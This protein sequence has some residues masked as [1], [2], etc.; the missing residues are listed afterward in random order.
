M[1]S[2]D[3]LYQDPGSAAPPQVRVSFAP[4]SLEVRGADGLLVTSW[5]YGDLRAV[6]AARPGQSIVL[7][8]TRTPA[9][10]LTIYD[11]SAVLPFLRSYAP[12]A[13]TKGRHIRFRW[14]YGLFAALLALPVILIVGLSVVDGDWLLRQ[15]LRLISD[16]IQSATEEALP[17]LCG[18]ADGQA[19]LDRLARRVA[20]AGGLETVPAVR[21]LD[22]GTVHSFVMAGGDTVYLTRGFLSRLRDGDEL[23]GWLAHEFG[24][25]AQHA[26]PS[27]AARSNAERQR[28]EVGCL[29]GDAELEAD[30]WALRALARAEVAASGL[31]DLIDRLP[32]IGL[33]AEW[34]DFMCTHPVTT[35]RLKAL[36]LDA[37]SGG[38]SPLGAAEWQAVQEICG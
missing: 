18:G 14:V 27:I 9:A 31:S 30:A 25:A 29:D 22:T 8:C 38:Q 33:R 11:G 7:T 28:L 13:A 2:F 37:P 4:R 15:A 23:A 19:V 16:Q 35:E 26:W 5:A 36:R 1:T 21:V 17:P 10:R 32:R 6:T 20:P 24:H 3:G 12:Q 34:S